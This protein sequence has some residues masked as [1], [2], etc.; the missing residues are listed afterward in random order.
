MQNKIVN[1]IVI[2]YPLREDCKQT[3]SVGL[4]FAEWA[5][6]TVVILWDIFDVYRQSGLQSQGIIDSLLDLRE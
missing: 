6:M 1:S 3:H 5:H 4:I 2:I